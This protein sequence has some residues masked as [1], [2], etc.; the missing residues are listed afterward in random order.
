MSGREGER[1]LSDTEAAF[2]YTHALTRGGG[3]LTTS[4]TVH[5]TFAPERVERA[6]RRWLGRL[7]LLSLRIAGTE[8]GLCF[9]QGTPAALRTEPDPVDSAVATWAGAD[10]TV[11]GERLWRLRAGPGQ[12]GT[13]CFRLTLHPAICDGYSV[14]RFVRPLLDALF[15]TPGPDAA[16]RSAR[17]LPPD[18]DELTYE[19]GGGCVCGV[20][21]AGSARRAGAA[22]VHRDG[23]GDRRSHGRTSGVGERAAGP[24]S[25][26]RGGSGAGPCDGRAAGVVTLALTPYESRRLRDWCGA[27][28]VTVSGFLTTVLADAL[29]R[30]T[31][32]TEVTAATAMSLRRRYA[33][34][35]LIAEPGC[36]LG[37]VRARLNAGAAGD[38][39]GRARAN[40]AV[41]CSAGRA[42]RP[43]RRAHAGIRHA[44]ERETT[45]R[46]PE[47]CVVDAGSVDTALGPH[48]A[49]ITGLRTVAA[50][51]AGRPGSSL[52]LS[53]FKGALTVALASRGLGEGWAARA[54]RELSE[55]VL[56]RPVSVR[57]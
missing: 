55:A 8:G 7:P 38:P 20:C 49:R 29:A 43:E 6:V 28:Q 23:R 47:V 34:R 57:L 35:T 53:S 2:A 31:G 25:E 21:G 18:T 54:E 15:D 12:A 44:V 41:L 40:A 13:T 33:E 51:G 36:V 1:A 56:T 30:E 5:G 10:D 37:I 22:T 14:G 19:G 32:G 4:F 42:W 24:V 45:A 9:R 27:G 26:L 3:R 50:R 16:D 48:A 11:A 17:A 52:Y 46:G 39:L